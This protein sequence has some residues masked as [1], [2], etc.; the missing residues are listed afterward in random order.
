MERGLETERITTEKPDIAVVLGD[1]DDDRKAKVLEELEAADGR[2]ETLRADLAERS[3][4]SSWETTGVVLER[5]ESGQARILGTVED[6]QEGIFFTAEMRPR[7]F[8]NEENPWR[9]GQA[10]RPM[11]TDAWDVEGEVQVVRETR[12]AGRKYTV[13]ETA[14]ELPEQRHDTVEAAVGAFT[15]LWDELVELAASRD[16]VAKAWYEDDDG[17]GGGNGGGDGDGDG[18]DDAD[19]P[20]EL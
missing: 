1:L 19:E 7:N 16:P 9:P 6:P 15:A 20:S 11:S 5:L 12:I 8:F 14:H 17:G 3:G 2:L 13:Q 10:A 18:D 4:R